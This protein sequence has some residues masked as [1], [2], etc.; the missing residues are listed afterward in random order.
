MYS[1][2]KGLYIEDYV[3]YGNVTKTVYGNNTAVFVNYS[4]SDANIDS[5]TVG[6]YGYTVVVEGKQVLTGGCA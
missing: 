6:A 3:N 4:D 2:I 5:V 1:Y